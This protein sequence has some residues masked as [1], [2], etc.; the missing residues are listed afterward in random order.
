MSRPCVTVAER[1]DELTDRPRDTRLR[2]SSI[3]I[4]AFRACLRVVTEG[5]SFRHVRFPF[6]L[7]T[8]YQDRRLF[9]TQAMMGYLQ[10][11]FEIE[12]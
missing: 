6:T 11:F 5:G 4:A 7:R 10:D 12:P 9:W 3:T 8:A 1:A 2:R